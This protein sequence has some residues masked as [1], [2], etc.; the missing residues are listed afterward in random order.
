MSK[1]H[2]Y[3]KNSTTRTNNAETEEK[4]TNKEHEENIII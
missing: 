2:I 4:H 3:N 1:N